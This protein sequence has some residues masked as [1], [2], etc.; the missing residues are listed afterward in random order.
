M[1]AALKIK[2]LTLS[3]SGRRILQGVSMSLAPGRVTALVGRS[4][5]GKSMTALAAMRLLPE[6]AITTGEALLKGRNLF[7]LN[8]AEMSALRGAEISMVFQEPMTALNPLQTIETQIAEVFL[9]HRKIERNEAIAAAHDLLRRVGLSPATISPRR[10][11]H[12]LSGGQRQRVVIAMAVALKPAVLLADEPTTALDA[13]TQG[14]ILSLLRS[15]C[16]EDHIALML[17]THDLAV[18]ADIADEIAVMQDSRIVDQATTSEIA[19]KV[20]EGAYVELMG[21]HRIGEKS[22]AGQSGKPVLKVTDISCTYANER[23]GFSF[24]RTR[25]SAVDKVSFEV[26]AGECLGVVGESGSG[27]STLARTLL[28]LQPTAGGT[29]EING[30]P[31]DTEKQ[32]DLRRLRRHAQIVFQD[33]YSSFNP[34]HRISQIVSEPLHLLDATLS[35]AQRRGRVVEALESVGLKPEHADCARAGAYHQS[36]AYCSRR[37]NVG[38]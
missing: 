32:A 16:T 26:R 12:E 21:A 18:V 19:K 10:Y 31:I 25:F 1:N 24:T 9:A 6:S 34:R 29:I 4:G 36:S 22:P 7:A 37:S 33:P 14:A 13:S 38:A 23:R 35:S 20:S 17:I 8:D 3:I 2:D 28:A 30:T 27:K 15:L 5:S 11:P